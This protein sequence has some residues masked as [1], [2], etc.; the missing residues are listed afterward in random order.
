[1]KVSL[2]IPP[3][4]YVTKMGTHTLGLSYIAA[5]LEENGHEVEIIDAVIE[6]LNWNDFEKRMKKSNPDIIGIT[7]DTNSR[8]RVYESAKRL[9]KIFDDDVPIVVGGPHATFTDVDILKYIDAIDFVVRGEGE[10]TMLELINA[11]EKNNPMK[12]IRGISYRKNGQIVRNEPGPPVLN[13]DELPYPARHLLPLEKYKSKL[14]GSYDIECTS[15]IFSRGCPNLCVFCSESHFWGKRYRFNSPS[16]VIDEINM[17]INEYGFKAIDFWDST[18]NAI[19]KWT[20]KVCNK[21]IEEKL[22]FKWYARVRVNLVNRELLKTMKKAGCV[23]LGVGIESGSPN[24]LKKINKNIT[25]QQIMKFAELCKDMDFFVKFF[26]MLN[27]PGETFDDIKM[28]FNMIKKLEGMSDKFIC[29]TAYTQIYPGTELE[30]LARKEGKLPK[31]FS[32]SLPY[33]NSRNLIVNENPEIPL[34]ENIKIE[35]LL[36]FLYKQN[37]ESITLKNILNKLIKIRSIQDL[38]ILIKKGILYIK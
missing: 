33:F 32:W 37:K 29:P 14:E 9:K 31:D 6:N 23:A 5:V 34:Y 30:M 19:P 4:S 10:Y 8:F 12:E 16:R 7:C 2:L 25:I 3:H 13:L 38:K 36:A 24:I 22:D 20:M 21:I 1:M 17:I 35:D 15:A 28:T 18:F 26:F 11:L 27:L